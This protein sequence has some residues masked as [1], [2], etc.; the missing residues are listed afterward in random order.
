MLP[1]EPGIWGARMTS[2]NPHGSPL[3]RQGHECELTQGQSQSETT[4]PDFVPAFSQEAKI[5]RILGG[6]KTFC[7]EHASIC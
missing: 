3:Y 7:R 1:G 2:L 6:I 5:F 4:G